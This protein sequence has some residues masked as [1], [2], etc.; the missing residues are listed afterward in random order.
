MAVMKVMAVVVIILV[1]MIVKVDKKV[2]LYRI[3]NGNGAVLSA[4]TLKWYHGYF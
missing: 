2:I 4:G 1:V 3:R